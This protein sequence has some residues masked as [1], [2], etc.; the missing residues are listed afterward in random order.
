MVPAMSKVG[1]GSPPQGLFP[2]APYQ[3]PL[4]QL[5]ADHPREVRFN[6]STIYHHEIGRMIEWLQ[7]VKDYLDATEQKQ[8]R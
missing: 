4:A 1:V 5:D 7:E 6:V 2:P 8:L 3:K